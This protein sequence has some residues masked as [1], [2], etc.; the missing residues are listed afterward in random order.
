MTTEEGTKELVHKLT[1]DLKTEWP[2]WTN[3]AKDFGDEREA[4][5]KI[6]REEK[7]PLRKLGRLELERIKLTQQEQEVGGI[8]GLLPQRNAPSYG[9]IEEG[10]VF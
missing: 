5:A 3:N 1:C 2:Q 4:C 9:R 8:L 6:L 7:E 10:E